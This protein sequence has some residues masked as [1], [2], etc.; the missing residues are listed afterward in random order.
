[1]N[2]HLCTNVRGTLCQSDEELKRMVGL[3]RHDG[4]AARNV[5]EV[6]RFLVEALDAGF[7]YIPVP[8]CDNFDRKKGCMG[9]GEAGQRE[10]E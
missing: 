10:A 8:E 7:D 5:A 4:Q 6:R 1:M 2:Y 9:H 3:L